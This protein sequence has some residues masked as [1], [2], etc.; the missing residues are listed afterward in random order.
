M[1]AWGEWLFILVIAC[2]F[3]VS[4]CSENETKNKTI[5]YEMYLKSQKDKVLTPAEFEKQIQLEK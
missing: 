2:V 5:R 3:L 4:Q 1:D